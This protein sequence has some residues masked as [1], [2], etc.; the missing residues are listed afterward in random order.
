MQHDRAVESAES[1]AVELITKM[2]LDGLKCKEIEALLER[3]F[4][5][6]CK[7]YCETDDDLREA[8]GI[9]EED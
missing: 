8:L 3:A 6:V 7:R 9:N 2:S 1:V 4:Y 5:K